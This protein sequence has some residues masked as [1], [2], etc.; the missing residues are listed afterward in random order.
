[1]A[2]QTQKQAAASKVLVT[3]TAGAEL[4]E[5]RPRGGVSMS[6]LTA[7]AL[8]ISNRMPAP[9]DKS[10]HSLIHQDPQHL[11]LGSLGIRLSVCLQTTGE[12]DQMFAFQITMQSLAGKV[13]IPQ[14][15]N[16]C[17]NGVYM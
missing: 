17:Q 14:R 10:R 5:Q 13:Q 16:A 7:I 1:M 8:V 6:K 2:L 9:R 15:W 12:T 4:I 11:G 3:H